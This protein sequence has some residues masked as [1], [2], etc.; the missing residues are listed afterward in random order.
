MKFILALYIVLFSSVLSA[1]WTNHYPKVEGFSHHVYLEGFELPSMNSGPTDPAPSPQ[2][3]EIA[4]SAKGWLWLLDPENGGARRIT[5]SAGM[6][7]RPQWSADGNNLVFV[8]D[9]GS[10]LSIVSLNLDSGRE[11]VLVDSEAI[12]LDPVFSLDGKYVYYASSEY[13]RME[14]WRVWL[15]TLKREE[16]NP[17]GA[18]KTRAFKR[19]PQILDQDSL[20]LYLS[21]SGSGDSVEVLNLLTNTTSSLARDDIT[22]QADLSLS[23]DRRYLA[24]TWPNDGGWQL[25]LLAIAAPQTSVLLTGGQGMP[26]SPAFSHDGEWVYFT[27]ADNDERMELKRISVYGGSV[28]TIEVKAFDW[29]ATTGRLLIR[30]EVDGQADAVRL[31]VLD[32][33]GHAVIP[34]RG[35]VR[36]EGQ[37]GRVFYY[38]GGE[39]ELIA[40]AG[41][42]TVSAV[43]GIATPELTQRV[44]VKPDATTQV[45]L[46]LERVWDAAANGWYSGDNHFHLNYGGSY[47]LDPADILPDLRGEGL[48]FAYPLLANLHNRF[49]EQKR[50]GW[51]HTER[52]IIEFGQEVRSHFLGHIEL[53][54][55]DRL[56]WPWVWGPY[57]QVYATDDRPNA[58]ALRFARAQ[59]GLGGYVHPYELQ[60]PFTEET[61][62]DVPV[63]FVA[64]A[65]LGEVDL[66][67]LACLWSDEIGT[68]ALWHSILNLG[69]PMA[70]SAG[71]D[72]M[73]NYYRTMAI[74]ATRVY[75]K[76]EGALST[77]SYLQALKQGRSFVSNG[78]MLEFAVAGL[79]PGQVVKVPGDRVEWTLDVHSA[80]PWEKVEIFV[81]G[82]VVQ[83]L[84]GHPEAGSKTYRGS[85]EPPAGGW[86]TARVTGANHGW[87]ALDSYLFAETS[88]VW[89]GDVGSTAPAALRQSAQNL[90]MVLD[91]SEKL[92]HEGYGN[93]PIPRLQSQFDEAR[94]RLQEL[95]G[96]P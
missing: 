14:L 85:V 8:R 3:G 55:I 63:G 66:I 72:V 95:A 75:V 96:K 88:P 89:F 39:I 50:W 68:G 10:R 42:I 87:P 92:L 16:V 78:P 56:F 28:E 83:T 37:N 40:P 77:A 58:E 32:S 21:K 29:G 4:I 48:D 6:D 24:Y 11:R 51:A 65:V 19:R 76:P 15:D 25:R 7:F 64:D 90:L 82:A 26:M 12:N 69:I 86:I 17:T 38:S 84:E 31:N 49:M 13:G 27:E 30:S 67:E 52:P 2:G 18:G 73:N 47:R 33:T 91:V 5:H 60:D 59:G 57:Y 44:R 9:S 34:E 80:L 45:T 71:S 46:R 54:G 36:S 94:A 1:Q 53:L 62:A 22:A 74:G 81:N 70:A 23:P 93:A 35:A 79:E 41:E 61:A 43:Q 20:L